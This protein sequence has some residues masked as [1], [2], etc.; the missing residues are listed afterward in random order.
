MTDASSTTARM[1]ELDAEF[2]V[3]SGLSDR[4][5]YKIFYSQVH[6][7]P[8]LVLGLNPG[9]ETDGTD[10]NAS[11]SF[12]EN[13]EHDYVAFRHHGRAYSL[14]GPMWELLSTALGTRSDDE[15]SRVPATNVVFRRSRSSGTLGMP[16]RDAA[17]ESAPVLRSILRAV[18]PKAILLLGGSAYS[19]FTAEHCAP[20]SLAVSSTPAEVTTPNGRGEA[21]IFRSAQA[22]V[23]ALDRRVPILMVGHPSKFARRTQ[24]PQV[25]SSVTTQLRRLQVAAPLPPGAPRRHSP[26]TTPSPAA[27][28]PSEAVA[29]AIS[30]PEAP[31]E[32][33]PLL[34]GADRVVPGTRL[35]D[36]APLVAVC[37]ALGLRLDDPEAPWP[38]YGKVVHLQGDR[39]AYLNRTNVD[40]R[41]SA[42]EV[43]NWHARGLGTLRPDN[44][45]Y[46]RISLPA[47]GF[48]S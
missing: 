24:W 20:G 19:L 14:A 25:L 28:N 32:P 18:D 23:I 6:A 9:G 43:A 2:R 35:G 29:T 47:A 21:C 3:H 34:I 17:R 40:V 12:Y 13:G 5:H 11:N 8:L 31:L 48:R 39:S 30:H 26:H 33:P 15:L 16:W 37:E 36:V 38:G 44:D 45:R 46:L 22:H 10:L 7:S 42:S 1:R 4:R 41:A 27:S